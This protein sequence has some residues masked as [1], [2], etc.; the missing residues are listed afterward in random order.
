MTAF[1]YHQIINYPKHMPKSF[2][3]KLLILVFASCLFGVVNGQ[4]P[5]FFEES[6]APFDQSELAD[7]DAD[8]QGRLVAVGRMRQFMQGGSPFYPTVMIKDQHGDPWS[9]LDPPDFGPTWYELRSVNFIPG[10]DGDFVA[11]G[12][13]LPDPLLAYAHGFL[14]RYYRNTNT[15]DVRSFQAPGALFHFIRD[16]VFDPADSTRL[17]I[18]GT[19]G[20]SDPGG[21]CFE[22]TTMVVDYNIN[23]HSYSVLPTTQKGGLWSI[24]PLPGGNFITAGIAAA[25]CDYLPDPIVLE[26]EQ[27][28]EI[29]HPNPPPYTNGFWY[30]ISALTALNDGNIFMVGGESF[31]GGADFRTLSYRYDPVTQE[32]TFYKPLDPDSTQSFLNQLWDVKVSPNGLIYAVGRVHYIYNSLHYRKVMI[33]SFDGESWRL[34][35]LPVSFDGGHFSEL[36]SLTILTNGQVYAAGLFRP[37][38]S[39]DPQ[40]LVMHNEIIT[41][42]TDEETSFSPSQFLLNQNYPNPFN[43]TTKIIYQIP[44]SPPLLKGESEAGGFITLKVYDILGNEVAT[45]VNEEKAPG[46]YEAIFDASKLVSG[47]Y[48]YTLTTDGFSATKKMILLR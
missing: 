5:F 29:V 41:A 13:Y 3:A 21:S 9:L 26:V 42:I 12:E 48:F 8:P 30:S 33:Q 19:R 25:D 16:A 22:F 2:S 1:K 18:V 34:H 7:I 36:S 40:T 10:S 43:P 14:L 32:Y 31:F 45:L 24:A 15:W 35:P 17:M 11:V 38:G 37:A 46:V 4:V 27:G 39:F 23:T 47:I 44:L 20:I 6:P 28:V